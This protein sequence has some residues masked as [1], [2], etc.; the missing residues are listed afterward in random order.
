MRDTDKPTQFC[1]G[2]FVS[3]DTQ[4]PTHEGNHDMP[5]LL[6]NMEAAR[7]DIRRMNLGLRLEHAERDTHEGSLAPHDTGLHAGDGMTGCV[8]GFMQMPHN[9]RRD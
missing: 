5:T 3:D 9:E 8:L 4:T 7:R 2:F 6:Q 1:V